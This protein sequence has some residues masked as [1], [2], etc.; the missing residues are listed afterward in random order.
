MLM[1]LLVLG[2][3]LL[4]AVAFFLIV[5]EKGELHPSTW[6]FAR[7]SGMH[8]RTL[9][10]YVYLRWTQQYINAL[11]G[12]TARNPTPSKGEHWLAQHY[13]GKVLT[14]E[15]ARCIINLDQPI[16]RRNLDQIVPYPIARD[17]IPQAS[18][19]IAVYECVCRNARAAH[20]EPTQVCMVVGRPFAD[21]VLEHHPDKSHRLSREEALQL[22]EA[23]HLRGHV[24]SAGFKDAM[25]NRFYAICHCC[26][27]CCGGI[28]EMA[29]RG[30]PRV[31][32]S[33]YVARID[34]AACALCDDCIE[35]CPFHAISKNGDTVIHD[36][37]RCLGCGVCEVMCKVGAITMVLD[38]RKGVPLDVRML[39]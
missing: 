30:V 21:F 8:L 28:R 1:L 16:N 14:H 25:L 29:E 37:E 33:G 17:F 31:A 27:C 5:G 13:H 12:M 15:H 10:G 19:D 24:H 9:H 32:S 2:V 11:F 34:P 36:W 39:A 22:L 4:T 18:P 20:S 7:E 26:K 3:L 38:E 23:E 35:A 6:A